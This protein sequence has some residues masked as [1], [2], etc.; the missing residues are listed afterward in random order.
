MSEKE[1]CV[2][3][4]DYKYASDEAHDANGTPQEVTGC[5]QSNVPFY[6]VCEYLDA[7]YMF[8]YPSI[9]LYL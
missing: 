6:G 5:L 7:N 4:S 2:I 9:L 8:L 3:P 1:P